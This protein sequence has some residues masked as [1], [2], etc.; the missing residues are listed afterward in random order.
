M[1]FTVPCPDP[2]LLSPEPKNNATDAPQRDQTHVRHD[3]GYISI[4]DDP[5][6]DEFRESVTV[7]VLVDCNAYKY[8]AGNRLVGI[9]CVC[10]G[11]GRESGDLETSTRPANDYDGLEM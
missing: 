6:I 2:E 9:N 1:H 10:G 7:K 4:L 11:D 5:S 8:R 3:W